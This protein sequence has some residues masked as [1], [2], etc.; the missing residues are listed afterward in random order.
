L[1]AARG[2]LLAG[3]LALVATGGCEHWPGNHNYGPPADPRVVRTL[4]ASDLGGRNAELQVWRDGA[5]AITIYELL[6]DSDGPH[7]GVTALYDSRGR[8]QLKLP[9]P[10]MK[11]SPEA[12]ERDRRRDQVLEDSKRS[13]TIEC[14]KDAG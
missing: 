11:T 10:D 12:L 13:E 14:G 2:G 8:E 4:C 6:P 3:L 7:A 1:I 5:T 9:A